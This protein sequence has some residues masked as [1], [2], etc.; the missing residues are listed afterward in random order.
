MG[1]KQGGIIWDIILP[2]IKSPRP[3]ILIKS[4]DHCEDDKPIRYTVISKN[5]DGYAG[6]QK[7]SM[8]QVQWVIY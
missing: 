3:A 8:G 4:L 7:A 1:A 2:L 6:N 5:K